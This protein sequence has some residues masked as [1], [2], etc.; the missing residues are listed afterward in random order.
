MSK[1][2]I[3]IRN[4]II[5]ILDS[6][7]G[8]PVLS[9]NLLEMSP[10]LNDMIRG[11]IYKIATG[12]EL[13]Q[14]SF[15]E[16]ES[17]VFSILQGFEEDYLVATSQELAKEL[18]AIM[19]AN[20][21]IPPADFL[22]ATYQVNGILHMALLKLNYKETFM[23]LTGNTE[24]GTNYNDIV[25]QTATLPSPSQKL[26]EA[27]LIN[28]EDFSVQVI[29]KKYDING[30]KENYLSKLF[31]KC[32][33]KMSQK[34]KMAIVNRAVEQINKKYFEEDFDKQLETKSI[35]QQE[36]QDSGSLHMDCIGEKMYGAIPEIKEEFTE[37][38]DKYNLTSDEICPQS[39]TTTKRYQK[40]YITT[41]TGIEINIPMDQYNENENVEFITDPEGTISIVIKNI[42][43]ISTR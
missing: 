24:E 22:V 14:C 26:S 17:K 21:E 7:V 35:I 3:I 10:D 12:D 29:E 11:Y 20:I 25:K 8:V 23:H 1:D 33:A 42:N 27:V 2:E 18:Y 39:E 43:H 31:L 41:D 34:T 38:L 16:G 40:Q 5:H 37:K 15:E 4:A 9:G 28:M 13:K 6:R 19:N 32:H 30:V 36:M